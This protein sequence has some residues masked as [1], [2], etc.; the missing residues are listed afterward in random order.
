MQSFTFML[1]NHVDRQQVDTAAVMGAYPPLPEPLVVIIRAA[2]SVKIQRFM[3]YG[4]LSCCDT[5]LERS[6]PDLQDMAAALGPC[7]QGEHT[8]EARMTSPCRGKG[9]AVMVRA[10]W[11]HGGATPRRRG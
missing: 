9:P 5:L 6:Q 2:M 3:T 4:R 10:G 1:G 8:L 7:L 11:R